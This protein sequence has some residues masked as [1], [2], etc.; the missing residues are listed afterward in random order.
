MQFSKFLFSNHAYRIRKMMW[1]L[2]LDLQLWDLGLW[3]RSGLP[4]LVL[5]ALAVLPSVDIMLRLVILLIACYFF[6]LSSFYCPSLK[7][8]WL[9]F[10]YSNFFS[11]LY[12]AYSNF[13]FIFFPGWPYYVFL[14]GASGHLAW[15]IWTVD[16]SSRADCNSKSVLVLV[17][18]F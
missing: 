1:K 15:Q 11:W 6:S 13:F 10:A 7:V 18:A 17:L 3:L 4:D 8:S 5:H 12:F 16:L 14:A 2:V 9:Y